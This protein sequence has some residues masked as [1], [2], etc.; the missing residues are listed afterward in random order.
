MRRGRGPGPRRG[1]GPGPRRGRRRM[2]RRSRRRTRRRRRRRVALVG[3]LVAF[4][5]YKLGKR[6]VQQVEQHSGRSVEE[7]SDQE[8]QQAASELGIQPEEMTVEDQAYVEQYGGEA[9]YEGSGASGGSSYIDELER[10]AHLRDQGYI[11]DAEFEMK[12]KQLLGA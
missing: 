3:G 11:T 2:V 12:K 4:G 6:Q 5:S 1:P 7:M 9:A 8:V 10:L